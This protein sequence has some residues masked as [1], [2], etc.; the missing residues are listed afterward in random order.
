MSRPSLPVRQ[1]GDPGAAS[2]GPLFCSA[3]TF[4]CF[5]SFFFVLTS[6]FQFNQ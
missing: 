1:G 4:F 5:G 2:A 3:V 6:D